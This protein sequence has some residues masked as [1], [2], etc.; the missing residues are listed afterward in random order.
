MKATL[1]FLKG[2]GGQSCKYRQ[3][4]SCQGERSLDTSSIGLLLPSE[5]RSSS[6]I[7]QSAK[8]ALEPCAPIYAEYS[9]S[10]QMPGAELEGNR[11]PIEEVSSERSPWQERFCGICRTVRLRL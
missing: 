1:L 11:R 7:V 8:S 10:F 5:F 6:G 4:R 9:Q 2:E 3:N